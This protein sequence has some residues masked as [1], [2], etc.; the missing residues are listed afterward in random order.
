MSSIT[1]SI[2]KELARLKAER[3]GL[4]RTIEVL[5]A[6]CAHFESLG[7]AVDDIDIAVTEVVDTP[8]EVA[9]TPNEVTDTPNDISD[10]PIVLVEEATDVVS[11]VTSAKTNSRHSRYPDSDPVMDELYRILYPGQPM[12]M[13][14]LHSLLLG[15]NIRIPSHN[16]KRYLGGVLYRDPRFVSEGPGR[17]TKW[18]LHPDEY[19]FHAINDSKDRGIISEDSDMSESEIAIASC[20]YD[21]IARMGKAVSV[22]D[23]I[24]QCRKEGL[25]A[26]KEKSPIDIVDIIDRDPRFIRAE[27]GRFKIRS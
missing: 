24:D 1:H 27:Y 22:A 13:L 9:N 7:P 21:L 2:K 6:T 20:V 10:A 14:E 23:T 3:S 15:R 17:Y 12:T 5:T 25:S 4:Q 19:T 26:W 16:T 11:Y 18:A 8:N